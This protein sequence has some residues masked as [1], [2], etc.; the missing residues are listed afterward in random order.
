MFLEQAGYCIEAASN[1]VEGIQKFEAGD[2]DL[3]LTEYRMPGLT[4]ATMAAVIKELKPD[5]PVLLIRE[6]TGWRAAGQNSVDALLPKPIDVNMLLGTVAKL[7]HREPG[8]G[9]EFPDRSP[10]LPPLSGSDIAT[11]TLY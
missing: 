8:D 9:R 10:E 6:I 7:L 1:G 3:V 11:E 2:I 4:G 5:T